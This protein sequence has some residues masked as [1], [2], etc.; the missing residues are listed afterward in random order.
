MSYLHIKALTRTY[1]PGVVIIASLA[2]SISHNP[3]VI[4][5]KRNFIS[6]VMNYR[7]FFYFFYKVLLKIIFKNVMNQSI[8]NKFLAVEIYYFLYFSGH[9]DFLLLPLQLC[10]LN[11][12]SFF[13]KKYNIFYPGNLIIL[14]F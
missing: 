4:F 9:P 1:Y 10:M 8:L 12:I 3:S 13:D 2:I 14:T 11:S 7:H 6:M 5:G